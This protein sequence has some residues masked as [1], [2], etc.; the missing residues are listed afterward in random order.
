MP[1]SGLQ[2]VRVYT[3]EQ[4]LE[5]VR[6]GIRRLQSGDPLAA[7]WVLLPPALE[8]VW[9][10]Q[11]ATRLNVHSFGFGRLTTRLLGQA[12]FDARL[13]RPED[14]IRFA[15]TIA[16][17]AHAEGLQSE[18][19]ESLLLPGFQHRLLVWFKEMQHQA[20]APD[21]FRDWAEAGGGTRN[22]DLALLYGRYVEQQEQTGM[23][24]PA[25]ALTHVCSL[26]QDDTA[27]LDL[28]TGLLV[29][30]FVGFTPLQRHCLKLLQ[31]CGTQVEVFLPAGH[32][33]LGRARSDASAEELG[34]LHRSAPDLEPAERRADEVAEWPT[35]EDEVRW[36]LRRVKRMLQAGEVELRDI[37]LC[38]P[39]MHDWNSLLRRVAAEY[40]IPL[41]L[42]LPLAEHPL[43]LVFRQAL[44][45]AP[46]FTLAGTWDLLLSPWLLHPDV[47]TDH[48]EHLRTLTQAFGVIR[49]REQWLSPFHADAD[50]DRHLLRD[51]GLKE[52]PAGLRRDLECAAQCLLDGLTPPHTQDERSLLNWVRGLLQPKGVGIGIPPEIEPA[53]RCLAEAVRLELEQMVAAARR[54][55][56]VHRHVPWPDLRRRLLDQIEQRSVPLYEAEESVSVLEFNNGWMVPTR[57]LFVLGLNEGTLPTTPSADPIF[58]V[59]ERA[60]HALALR[61][62]D[63]RTAWLQWDML[64]AGCTERLYLSR[65]RKSITGG[66]LESG[67]V[68]A[69]PFWPGGGDVQTEDERP[70]SL[71]ELLR[72]TVRKGTAY[73][74]LA[75]EAGMAG[76]LE[77]VAALARVDA[78]RANTAAP[79]CYEGILSSPTVLHRLRTRFGTDH[80]WSPSALENFPVCPLGFFAERVLGLKPDETPEEG[81]SPAVEGNIYH[82]ALE[83]IYGKLRGRS[84]AQLSERQVEDLVSEVLAEGDD[85]RHVRLKYQPYPLESHDQEQI[86]RNLIKLVLVDLE[87]AD[88]L[89]ADAWMPMYHEKWMEWIEDS[90]LLEETGSVRLGGIADRIDVDGEG[91]LRVIDY[92]RSGKTRSDIESGKTLQAVL[93][94]RA[95]HDRMGPVAYSAYWNVRNLEQRGPRS[96]TRRTSPEIVAPHNEGDPLV[97][98]VL[99][100]LDHIVADVTDGIFPSAPRQ[101]D[102]ATLS[103]APW[104][105]KAEFCQPS[106]QSRNKGRR[107]LKSA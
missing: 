107:R 22:R 21:A 97:E 38:V 53:E 59:R 56:S 62:H 1:M 83:R 10:R 91:N 26:L 44:R 73:G 24:D 5:G 89:A 72:H 103:C 7:V 43:C 90:D 28:A 66:A 82:D 30:G 93:Y 75:V 69:S 84:L 8:A 29:A 78:L 15:A 102:R 32:S 2:V 79:A 14:Q 104:C 94:G 41:H 35:A 68:P 81:M 48:L 42:S 57:H 106:W 95:V 9:R 25:V 11:P 96:G 86:R 52:E 101:L 58:S 54:A 88:H 105:G 61:T 60:S 33:E 76:D 12:G 47:K 40:R 16:E 65:S 80:R 3:N 34:G 67:L 87:D 27:D 36:V 45:M 49:G 77:R 4:A 64:V 71:R 50:W 74:S 37:T 23:R 63:H 46:E 13:L 6:E 31:Q 20:I 85:A 98:A 39:S 18:I 55:V 51:M 99:E 17:E 100:Q 19:Q 70:A 92:K